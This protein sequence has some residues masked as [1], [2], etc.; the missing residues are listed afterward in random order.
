MGKKENMKLAD[1]YSFLSEIAETLKKEYDVEDLMK[2]TYLE[3]V[4]KVNENYNPD[5]EEE[6]KQEG[7]KLSFRDN[8]MMLIDGIRGR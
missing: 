5:A 6:K 7:L 1:N 4:R 3:W 2:M 8:L